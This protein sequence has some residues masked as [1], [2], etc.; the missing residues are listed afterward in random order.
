MR[1]LTLALVLVAI[2]L[3]SSAGA[4]DRS[5]HLFKW[6]QPDSTS[7]GT[8]TLDGWIKEYNIFIATPSD[9]MLYG[10]EAAPHAVADTASAYVSLLIGV[11]SSVA[12]SATDIW[13]Q[14]GPLSEWSDSYIPIPPAPG[15]G[16]KP[17]VDD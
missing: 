9:T 16:G 15:T 17:F 1:R 6:T 8:E 14:T 5:L 10:V 2:L 13:G 3:A 4:Q 12:V 7:G 11:P